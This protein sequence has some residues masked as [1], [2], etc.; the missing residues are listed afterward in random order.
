VVNKSEQAFYQLEAMIERGELEPDSFVSESSLM[1]V[2]GLGRTPTR[3][4]VQRLARNH[5]L[6][7]HPNKGIE[8]PRISVEDQLSRLEVRR[9][10]EV[11]AVALA[12]E[13]ATQRELEAIESLAATLNGEHLL[14]D[15]AETVRQTH[16]LILAASHNFYLAEAMVPLQ[17][18]SRRFWLMHVRDE[19]KE[20]LEGSRLHR[21][22]LDAIAVRDREAARQ[23]SL[24]LNDYLVASAL[25]VVTGRS[26]GE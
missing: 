26:S 11:L 8:I 13:R 16:S 14:H 17:G 6:R 12:C 21:A 23:A 1:Q 25:S 7:I 20:V 9:A 4:A 18:M 24:E 19:R 2:T 3:E 10:V 5:M 22:L 15:Y